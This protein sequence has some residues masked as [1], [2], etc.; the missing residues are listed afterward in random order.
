MK[1]LWFIENFWF[2][3]FINE[4][5]PRKGEVKMKYQHKNQEKGERGVTNQ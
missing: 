4:N 3:Y 2:D 1:S 5:L